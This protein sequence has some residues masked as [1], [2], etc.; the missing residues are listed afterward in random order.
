MVE[1]VCAWGN[2][3]VMVGNIRAWSARR[4]WH[5]LNTGLLTDSTGQFLGADLF[6]DTESR[7]LNVNWIAP[8]LGWDECC[9]FLDLPK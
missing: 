2:R 1:S 8:G 9:H 3:Q 6:G 4:H 7:H 5:W